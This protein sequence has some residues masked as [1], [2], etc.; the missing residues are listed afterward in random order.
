L[1][2]LYAFAGLYYLLFRKS[3][4]GRPTLAG[5]FAVPLVLAF[6][7]GN[8]YMPLLRQ[9][10]DKQLSVLVQ[11]G[12]GEDPLY[13]VL[14][15]EIRGWLA[16]DPAR[17]PLAYTCGLVAIG[18]VWLALFRSEFAAE[19]NAGTPKAG[20]AMIESFGLG[21]GLLTGL[22]LSIRNGAKGWFN[23]YLGD[24]RYWS[25]VLWRYL[26]PTFLAILIGLALWTLY[27]RARM[28]L[29]KGRLP[30]AYGAIWLVLVVQNTIAQLVTGPWSQWHEVAFSIYYML[31]FFITAVII[32]HCRFLKTY[33]HVVSAEAA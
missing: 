7:A 5:W 25:E 18:L 29:P 1:T 32:I 10:V 8:Y 23:I 2:A 11:I 21:L 14:A 27:R 24:E 33:S 22:G 20:D 13:S 9:F 31:L 30:Y 6:I 12:S 16:R 15:E 26:G 4:A 3:A 17:F 28:R 19:K